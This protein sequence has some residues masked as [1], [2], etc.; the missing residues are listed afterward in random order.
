[1]QQITIGDAMCRQPGTARTTAMATEKIRIEQHSFMGSLWFGGWL[2]TLGY[3]QLT[4]W[5]GLLALV[6]WPY[7]IGV[8]FSPL[9][10]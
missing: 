6:L 2:F 3:L 1:L 9:L 10:R 4:F 5:K 7:Y 8:A